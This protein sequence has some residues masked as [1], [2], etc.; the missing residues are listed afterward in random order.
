MIGKILSISESFFMI[1]FLIVTFM[2]MIVL[3][4]TI[5]SISYGVFSSFLA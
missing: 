5:V 2:M 1:L 3:G 4:I